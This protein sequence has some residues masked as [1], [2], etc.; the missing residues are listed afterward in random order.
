MEKC[1]PKFGERWYGPLE[2][3][4]EEDDQSIL[5]RAVLSRAKS[6]GRRLR[7]GKGAD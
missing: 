3:V 4:G 7:I 1:I 2:K 5:P 6:I